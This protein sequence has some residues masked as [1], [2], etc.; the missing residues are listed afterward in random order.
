MN[1]KFTN[2]KTMEN[3]KTTAEKEKTKKKITENLE[4]KK[5]D[6]TDSSLYNIAT[7]IDVTP[8]TDNFSGNGGEFGGGGAT[9]EY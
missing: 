2:F 5:D 7:P 4:T 1:F 9:G 8:T 3:K 6:Y